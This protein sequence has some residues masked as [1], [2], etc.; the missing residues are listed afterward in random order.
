MKC[1]ESMKGAEMYV[2]L[3][4]CCHYGKTPP[5]TEAIINS[6][7]TT[8]YVGSK[9]P[10]PLVAGKGCELL[11]QNGITV[12]E[13]ICKEREEILSLN[14][15]KVRA[16]APVIEAVL[17]QDYICVVG[18]SDKIEEGKELFGEVKDLLV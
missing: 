16:L 4:P 6:G 14:V 17:A 3:E 8:V 5:C 10:N 11:R 7:I 9:D 2:T 15:Q 1:S 13:D 18:N 12:Y